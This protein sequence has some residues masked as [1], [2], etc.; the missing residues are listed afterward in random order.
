MT[1]SRSFGKGLTDFNDLAT[2]VAAFVNTVGRRMREQS[3]C[4]VSL[5][6][7]IQTDFFKDDINKYRNSAHRTLSEP[8]ADTMTLTAAAIDALR[9]IFR[10]GY[11]FKKAG[12]HI[13]ELTNASNIQQSLFCDPLA[14]D[15]HKRLMNTIDSINRNTISHDIVHTGAYQPI[16]QFVRREKPSRLFSTRISDIITITC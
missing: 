6:V 8:T 1:C 4:A 15:K 11:A 2:A 9:S 16:D 7:Y 3:L 5:A 13:C 10:K 14:R 12:I